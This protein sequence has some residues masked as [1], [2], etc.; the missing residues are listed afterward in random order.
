MFSL[1]LLPSAEIMAIKNIL[2]IHQV[3]LIECLK[4]QTLL[5]QKYKRKQTN[6]E[7]HILSNSEAVKLQNVSIFQNH[8][9]TG[10]NC[11]L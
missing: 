6:I 11:E 5:K 8:I 1:N 10:V 3:F 7:S 9:F 2:L 4:C